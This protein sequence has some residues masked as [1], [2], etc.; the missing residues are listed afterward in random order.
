MTDRAPLPTIPAKV[1]EERPQS[2]PADPPDDDPSAGS[3]AKRPSYTPQGPRGGNRP[4]SLL[5]SFLSNSPASAQSMGVTYYGYRWYDPATG[6]WPSRDPIGERGGLNLY[7]FLGNN[8]VG[9]VDR[10][11]LEAYVLLYAAHD[12]GGD[13]IFKRWAESIA[14]KIKSR[15]VT[16]FN[17]PFRCFD[18]ERDTIEYIEVNSV[19]DLERLK[20]IKD[21]RY[22]ASFGD[23]SSDRFWY[24]NDRGGSTAVASD[25]VA[26]RSEKSEVVNL[27]DF[28]NMIDWVGCQTSICR[29]CDAGVAFELYHCNSNSFYEPVRDQLEEAFNPTTIDDDGFGPIPSPTRDVFVGGFSCG[30]SNGIGWPNSQIGFRGWPRPNMESKDRVLNP[31]CRPRNMGK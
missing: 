16:D 27:N 2:R 17:T 4:N 18:P 22:V 15:S 13:G 26:M 5:F 12:S 6:R 3:A 9:F 19:S 28:A 11:G 7:Q 21:V 20:T 25:G 31:N 24:L 14:S 30:V 29:G 1:A 8:G 23:G 10:F